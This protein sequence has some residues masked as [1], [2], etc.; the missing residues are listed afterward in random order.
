[1]A[2]HLL[3]AACRQLSVQVGSQ[4]HFNRTAHPWLLAGTVVPASK[5]SILRAITTVARWIKLLTAASVARA[6]RQFRGRAFLRSGTSRRRLA[7]ARSSPPN[8]SGRL[9][10]IACPRPLR[11][12]ARQRERQVPELRRHLGLPR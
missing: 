12:A 11:P 1:M 2:L 9:T 6:P 3:A 10:P 8:P 5:F 7:R 4:I